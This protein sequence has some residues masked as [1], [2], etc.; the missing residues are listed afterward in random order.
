M[1]Y[2]NRRSHRTKTFLQRRGRPDM[3]KTAALVIVFIYL[4]IHCAFLH[5]TFRNVLLCIDKYRLNKN[6]NKQAAK[7][8]YSSITFYTV[9]TILNI[10]NVFA[11]V[12]TL[13][14]LGMDVRDSLAMFLGGS[15][16]LT[17]ASGICRTAEIYVLTF[18][19]YDTVELWGVSIRGILSYGC[20]LMK[21]HF[22]HH[23]WSAQAIVMMRL[24][25]LYD[26]LWESM[27]LDSLLAKQREQAATKEATSNQAGTS[28]QE[29][30]KT[31][32]S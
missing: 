19:P 2:S 4:I 31:R 1:N 18:S 28:A 27:R 9:R 5:Y 3:T 15:I 13:T 17:V 14:T 22:G 12:T 26:D 23:A 11:D 29:A 30:M 32:F 6:T 21:R 10:I 24:F 8:Y 25:D 16:V 7:V 20:V